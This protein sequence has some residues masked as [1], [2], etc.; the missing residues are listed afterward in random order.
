MVDLMRNKSLGV[1]VGASTVSFVFTK[2]FRDKIDILSNHSIIH[3]GNPQKVL[4]N[5]FQDFDAENHYVVITGRKFKQVDNLLCEILVDAGV[6]EY[7]RASAFQPIAPPRRTV[8][9]FS[10]STNEFGKPCITLTTPT[11]QVMKYIRP[12]FASDMC[13]ATIRDAFKTML[14]SGAEQ[15]HTLQGPEVPEQMVR[16]FIEQAK[17][18]ARLNGATAAKLEQVAANNHGG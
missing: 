16:D 4:M 14:W 11:G 1:C 8:N 7:A 3:E 5:F 18:E 12:D 9:S 17:H 10:V 6:M 15:K 13:P 2:R